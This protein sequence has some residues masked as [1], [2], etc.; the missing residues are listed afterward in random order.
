VGLPALQAAG[1]TR[2]IVLHSTSP[3]PTQ[4]VSL[5][6]YLFEAT[7]LRSW[8][9]KTLLEDDGALIILQ[10][11]PNE[12]YIAGSGLTVSFFRDPDVDTK[13]SGIASIEGVARSN[14]GWT[15]LRRL[16][17]D[18]TNHGRQLSLAPHQVHAYR[19]ILSSIEQH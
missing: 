9:A 2:A 1:S 19:V 5:G 15:T 16:N 18:Q 13:I 8:P 14:G 3:R 6:G 7:L 4:T 11:A 17:G 10:T 12:F